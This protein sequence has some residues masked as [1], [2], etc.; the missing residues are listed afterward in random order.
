MIDD[1][2]QMDY[3][4]YDSYKD[5]GVDWLGEIPE[6]WDTKRLKYVLS[7]RNERSKTGD[8]PLLMVSQ[9]YGLVIRADY[10]AKATVALSSVDNKIVYK[11]D[12]VSIK[13]K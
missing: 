11:N 10:H 8:E 5:S 9:K 1:L 2:T 13:A 7:E 6:G 3:P 4:R 12:L